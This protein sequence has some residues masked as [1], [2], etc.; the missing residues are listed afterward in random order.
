MS[1][2]TDSKLAVF[3]FAAIV[4]LICS[5]VVSAAAVSL[6]SIQQKNALNEKRINILV[7]A[8]L[9]EPGSELKGKEIEARFKQITSVVVNLKTGE[10]V[11]DKDPA[12]YD[13]Y[14]AAESKKEGHTLQDDPANIKRIAEDGSAYLLIKDGKIERVILPVQGYG[15]WST[16]YGFTALSLDNQA[17]IKGLT[18]YQQ[19]ETP[20]LGARITEPQW[21]AKWDGV[22][23]K[24]DDN[25][26]AHIQVVKSANPDKDWQVD[27]ISGATLTSRGVEHL[28]NFWLGKQG[29]EPFLRR[30]QDGSI[31]ASSIEAS[32][33]G[34]S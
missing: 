4:C 19:G 11:S 5:L 2:E 23:P 14:K 17:T 16:M 29:Y 32:L 20:G 34:K 26:Q 8:G 3:R 25:G 21:Q 7:A 27:G 22:N 10:L 15:L 13:M 28:M 31:T 6:R 12:S 33:H 30:I 1:K 24:Y 18:F 9:A